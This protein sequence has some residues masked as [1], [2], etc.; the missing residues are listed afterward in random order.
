VEND[1]PVGNEEADDEEDSDE[2]VGED[3]SGL[4]EAVVEVVVS[5]LEEGEEDSV[6][7][8]HRY[9]LQDHRVLEFLLQ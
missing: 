9:P 8:E 5:E 4:C 2:G 3:Q 7:D 1:D 6:G